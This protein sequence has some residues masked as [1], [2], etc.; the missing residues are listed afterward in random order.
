V[1][2][3]PR[4]SGVVCHKPQTNASSQQNAAPTGKGH[5]YYEGEASGR[6]GSLARLGEDEVVSPIHWSFQA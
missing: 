1:C 5:K 2:H 4:L 3:E 6:T